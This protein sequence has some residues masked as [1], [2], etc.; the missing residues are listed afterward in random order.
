M[1]TLSLARAGACIVL[2]VGLSIGCVPGVLAIAQEGGVS[3]SVAKR[4]AEQSAQQGSTAAFE[5][6]EVVY[7]TLD[8]AGAPE[9]A[10]VVN[11]FEVSEA[12]SVVDWGAYDEV[13]NLTNQEPLVRTDEATVFEAQ[14][15]TFFYQGS[16]SQVDL[17]WKVSLPTRLTGARCLL[18]TS[19]GQAGRL[20]Y[21]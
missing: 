1:R 21:T 19:R 4:A 9:E 18:Q 2:T 3:A 14:E 16:V 5:K 6:S 13:S 10:Y 15:G 20:R 7:A 12:G 17:P 8:A 11:R